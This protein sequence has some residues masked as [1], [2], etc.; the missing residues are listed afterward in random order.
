[1]KRE[2]KPA[3]RE[4]GCARL[5]FNAN[6]WKRFCRTVEK[7]ETNKNIYSNSLI[8]TRRR[9]SVTKPVVSIIFSRDS[10]LLRLFRVP[11]GKNLAEFEKKDE[12]VRTLKVRPGFLCGS[13]PRYSIKINSV[14]SKVWIALRSTWISYWLLSQPRT[15]AQISLPR[16]Y[17]WPYKSWLDYL[18]FHQAGL[19]LFKYEGFSPKGFDNFS[20]H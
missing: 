8:K 13:P 2:K 4:K 18:D 12:R 6:D 15:S 17:S 9:S 20:F 5:K 1:M 10:L 11:F 14:A 3:Q 16:S 19:W 7:V